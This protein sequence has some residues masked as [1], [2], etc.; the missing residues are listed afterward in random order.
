LDAIVTRCLQPN[1]ANRY[2]TAVELATAIAAASRG[3]RGRSP[4][5]AIA[6]RWI[7]RVA[8]AALVAALAS[9]AYWTITHGVV[10]GLA[11]SLLPVSA[12]AQ[13]VAPDDHR[14]AGAVPAVDDTRR[15]LHQPE[16]ARPAPGTSTA[17]DAIHRG[18][19]TG[20]AREAEQAIK[21]HPQSPEA[22]LPLAAA[23]ALTAPATAR[24]PYERMAATGPAGASLAAAGLADLALYEGR[25]AEAAEILEAAIARDVRTSDR[26][27]L[28]TKYVALAEARAGQG[29]QADALV[30]IRQALGTSR[31]ESVLLPAARLLITLHRED[32]ARS[33]A[34]ELAASHD[35]NTRAYGRIVNAELALGHGDTKG[36]IETLLTALKTSDLWLVRF[37]LGTA[38]LQSDRYSDA[39]AQFQMCEV[40]RGEA[41]T[42]FLDEGPS[43]RYLGM[44]RYLLARAREGA[45]LTRE[46]AEDFRQF[47]ILRAGSPSGSA[48]RDARTRLA[49]IAD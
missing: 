32:A 25:H 17:A 16:A 28:A 20:A 38:Y 2:Q 1:P 4:I 47:L 48:E 5:A 15:A 21:A 14:K 27:G 23:A 44:L 49:Q 45:G 6:K 31:D 39:L 3:E 11:R 7:P 46:A 42:L 41:T 8:V 12:A 9:L 35:P 24:A 26:T 19:L 40:R 10:S 18:D 36:A 22:Y 30:A 29:R 13:N 34:N 37:V 33:L 43:I